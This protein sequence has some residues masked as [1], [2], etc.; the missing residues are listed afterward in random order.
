MDF[1]QGLPELELY[2]L[3]ERLVAPRIPFMQFR[4]LQ[5]GGQ[6]SVIGNMV[7]VPND[8]APM[9][10][11][12]PRHMND[13]DT[14]TIKFKRKRQYKRW[15]LKENV[16][17]LAVWKAANYLCK[18]SKLYKDVQIDTAWLDSLQNEQTECEN[19]TH[20]SNLTSNE[21]YKN[22]NMLESITIENDSADELDEE[23]RRLGTVHLDTMLDDHVL[24]DRDV[25]MQ[26][27]DGIPNEMTFAPGEG[28]TPISVFQDENAEYLA[29]PSIFCGQTRPT[30]TEREIPVH[31]SDI[32]KYELQCVDR[33]AASNV[34]N[35]FFKLKKLQTK[36]VLD[37]VTLAVRR[38]KTKGKKL[39][40]K[41]ILDDVQCQRLINLDEGY[42]IFRTI[43]NSPAYLEK[44]KKDAFAM[45]RQLGFP[46]LFISQSAVETKWP[47]LL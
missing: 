9:V 20:D 18:N 43:C 47:E 45:I 39:K 12:L 6:Q 13:T 16:R 30:N 46:A 32:C 26:Q 25:D 14:I 44:H 40:V 42:Y 17:P 11:T 35:L 31:Y 3:E 5:C 2:P 4:Q 37:K 1:H 23:S 27:N 22:H 33:R 41:D 29:F 10:N 24:Q 19:E 36:Q 34:A 21:T 15:E 28:Q 7:N 38:C 8:I